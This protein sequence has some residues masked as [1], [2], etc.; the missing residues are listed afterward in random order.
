[1]TS[2]RTLD[3]YR[4]GSFKRKRVGS[5]VEYR[6]SYSL[7]DQEQ[8]DFQTCVPP[9]IRQR[10]VLCINLSSHEWSIS[11]PDHHFSEEFFRFRPIALPYSFLV[12][13]RLLSST[14]S[15]HLNHS[16]CLY[17]LRVLNSV[18]LPL[19]IKIQRYQNKRLYG[20]PEL[21]L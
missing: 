5:L 6:R 18:V 15:P 11:L 12:S 9:D 14:S 17:F 1:M 2:Y 3:S 21:H 20:T 8:L 13:I 4:S 16:F 7:L 10:L 19:I